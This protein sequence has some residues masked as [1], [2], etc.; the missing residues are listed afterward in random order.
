MRRAPVLGTV[1]VSVLLL[2]GCGGE[3]VDPKVAYVEQATGIC[4]E[5]QRAFEALPT[6]T[7][8]EGFAPYAKELVGILETAET[9]LSGLTP[10]PDD[11]AELESKVLEPFADV[12]EQGKTF[13]GD[14]EAAGT[15]QAKLLGLLAQRP[16]AAGVDTEFLR[17][18]GLPTCADAIEQAG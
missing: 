18:Y 5:A 6:P 2:S 15:D 17:T 14:V 3:E 9:E 1:L 12:V 4:D 10:P 13:A 7:T 16:S 11:E 8:P